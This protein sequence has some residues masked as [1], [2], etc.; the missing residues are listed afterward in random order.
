MFVHLDGQSGSFSR[1]RS[2]FSWRF[3]R[4]RRRCARRAGTA[5]R[6]HDATRVPQCLRIALRYLPPRPARRQSWRVRSTTSG[7]RRTGAGTSGS[8]IGGP[9][10][11]RVPPGSEIRSV[12]RRLTSITGIYSNK[13]NLSWRWARGSGGSKIARLDGAKPFGQVR[14]LLP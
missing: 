10:P 2:S 6:K 9:Y 7:D 8:G 11:K 3:F 14:I 5:H 13:L 1:T 4:P 12:C